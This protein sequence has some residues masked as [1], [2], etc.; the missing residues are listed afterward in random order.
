MALGLEQLLLAALVF[1]NFL[2]KQVDHLDAFD[3][4]QFVVDGGVL[5][6]EL[7]VAG[8]K[9][10]S[11]IQT[12]RPVYLPLPGLLLPQLVLLLIEGIFLAVL[13]VPVPRGQ[14]PAFLGPLPR[15]LL[16]VLLNPLVRAHLLYLNGYNN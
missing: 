6:D 2:Q 8:G 12:A 7:R 10:L 1:L 5:A 3:L 14:R 13:A 15:L 9:G 4:L 16:L 11:F